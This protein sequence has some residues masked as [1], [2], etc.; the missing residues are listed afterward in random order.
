MIKLIAI[1]VFFAL[2]LGIGAYSG[3]ILVE[4]QK[5]QSAKIESL[6]RQ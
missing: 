2:L 4:Y 6:I 1:V 5:K 3:N